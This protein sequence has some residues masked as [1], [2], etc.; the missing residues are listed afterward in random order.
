LLADAAEAGAR[1]ALIESGHL[2]QQSAKQKHRNYM[3]F[4]IIEE[5]Q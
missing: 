3:D 5:L 1:K 4:I 2:T